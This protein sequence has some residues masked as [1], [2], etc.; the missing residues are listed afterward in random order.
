MIG[1]YLNSDMLRWLR[2]AGSATVIGARS[3]C[4]RPGECRVPR[5]VARIRGCVVEA[6]RESSALNESG[7]P[8]KTFGG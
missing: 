5:L 3:D 1:L 8:G 6:G 2:N 4:L 7:G